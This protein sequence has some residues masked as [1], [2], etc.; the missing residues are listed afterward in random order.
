[1][2]I[3]VKQAAIPIIS[4]MIVC[5]IVCLYFL[6]TFRDETVCAF[7]D[8]ILLLSSLI[9]VVMDILSMKA[10]PI[11]KNIV[12]I[13]LIGRIGCMVL[14][15]LGTGEFAVFCN[16]VD[17]IN[18]LNIALDYFVGDYSLRS[19]KYPYVLNFLFQLF[20]PYHLMAQAINIVFW[21]LGLKI[22]YRVADRD[23]LGKKKQWLIA[24][25]CLLPMQIL[26]TS[27][28]L[29]ES[30]MIFFIMLSVYY[31][32]KYQETKN[33]TYL[34][35]STLIALPSILLHTGCIA[36]WGVNFLVY[37]MWD[38]DT[39]KWKIFTWKAFLLVL[40]I[41]FMVP[42]YE[43]V[44]FKVF[45]DY[46]PSTLS[47]ESLTN[48]RYEISRTDYIVGSGTVESVLEFIFS[49]V[50]RCVYFWLSPTPDFWSSPIDV[51]AFA[52]DTLP[53]MIF[54]Y[55]FCKQMKHTRN[56]RVGW[57]GACLFFV[58]TLIYAWGTRNA[59]AAMRHRDMLV[60]PMVMLM[61]YGVRAEK[62]VMLDGE[63][64]LQKP[65]EELKAI[66]L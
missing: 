30:I 16:Q 39:G 10:S 45:P 47:I 34:V 18:F 54:L 62:E 1:M 23:F 60:G 52:L 6:E 26:I 5:S 57:L 22:I 17:Q 9:V 59:G 32:G 33:I 24:F 55:S 53:W 29:R 7:I 50:Y 12:L 19:T 66:I 3:R 25:Y 46:L 31:I 21:Y 20:G 48:R 37:V 28:L 14:P 2:I 49:T 38:G 44:V 51:I 56:A 42:I 11:T 27:S 36:I 40:A 58:F 65:A 13:S 64:S 15:L 41:T 8:G 35:F 61:L 63:D 4:L 43:N